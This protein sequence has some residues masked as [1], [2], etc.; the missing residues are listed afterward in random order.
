M[1]FGACCKRAP[2]SRCDTVIPSLPGAPG[3]YSLVVSVRRTARITVGG[4]GV[5]AFRPGVYVYAGSARGGLRRRVR[6]YLALSST[7]RWHIDHLLAC[8][9]AHLV[10]VHLW[11]TP[12]L[13][14]C[15]L[16]RA[17]ARLGRPVVPGFGSSD[18]REGCVSHLTYLA[19]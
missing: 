6:R 1:R 9:E 7:R 13:S 8:P 2:A 11:P 19:S 18:C 12:H 16:Q 14:E 17:V 10:A 15:L 3:V 4:L 5:V